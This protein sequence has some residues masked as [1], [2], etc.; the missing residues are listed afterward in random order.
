MKKLLLSFVLLIFTSNIY[1]QDEL[2]LNGDGAGGIWNYAET[3][4]SY[5]YD[6]GGESTFLG[7][8]GDLDYIIT[9]CP[10]IGGNLEAIFE[11]F[12]LWTGDT[13]WI[14]DGLEMITESGNVIFG[15]AQIPGSP[16]I[17]F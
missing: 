5:L 9:I 17:V 7:Q 2:L 14:Y 15:T 1:C 8:S 11:Y 16:F 3:C 13:L 4:S 6:A 10:D 12:Y